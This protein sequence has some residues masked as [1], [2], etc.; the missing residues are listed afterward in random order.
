M[1]SKSSEVRLGHLI[2]SGYHGRIEYIGQMGTRIYFSHDLDTL[3]GCLG[4]HLREPVA[5]ADPFQP[6]TVI[7]PNAHMKR[8][9][10]ISLAERL[11]IVANVEFPILPFGL[12]QLLDDLSSSDPETE[13][14]PLR[15]DL[16]RLQIMGL[17]LARTRPGEADDDFAQ[18]AF[19]L[20]DKNGKPARNFAGRLWQISAQLAHYF[21]EYEFHRADMIAAWRRNESFKRIP[22]EDPEVEGMETCQRSLYNA[23]FADNGLRDQLAA[24]LQEEYLTLPQFSSR[25][26]PKARPITQPVH[27]FALSQISSY[28]RNLLFRLGRLVDLHVYQLNLCSE[29]WEDVTTEREDRWLR[30]RNAK[31][32]NEHGE[33]VLEWDEYENMLLKWWGKPGRESARL[34]SE[35]ENES[36]PELNLEI[37]WLETDSRAPGSTVLATVQQQV[38]RRQQL[39]EGDR[40][41]QDRSL[42]IVAAPGLFREIE[43]IHQSVIDNLAADPTLK[44]TD[45]AILVPDINQY[46]PVIDAVFN[47]RPRPIEYNLTDSTAAKDSIYGQAVVDLLELANGSFSRREVFNLILNPCFLAGRGI[48]RDDALIWAQWAEHLQI[49]HSFD[50]ADKEARG[51]TPNRLFTW[52]QGLERLRFGRIMLQ[53]PEQHFHE[54]VP[55]A[56]MQSGDRQ[57]LSNF[58]FTIEALFRAIQRIAAVELSCEA[59]L[60]ELETVLDAFLGIPND[61]PEEAM[62]RRQLLESMRGHVLID[63]ILD[64]LDY[65]DGIGFELVVQMVNACLDDIASRH[66]SFL[67][68]G[69]NVAEIRANRAIPHRIVYIAGMREGQFPGSP[70]V[71]TLDLRRPGR[72]IGDISLPEENRF[73]ILETL[74]T[75]RDK[76]YLS[77]VSRDL[78]KDQVFYP[79]SIIV[80]LKTY[81]ERAV[82]DGEFRI[83]EVP[84]SSADE[85]YLRWDTQ[86]DWSDVIVNR[87]ES[88]RILALQ[89]LMVRNPDRISPEV[90]DE[91]AAR[92]ERN[93][94]QARAL[95]TETRDERVVLRLRDLRRF[96]ENPIEA[97]F[98]TQLSI[99]EA[100]EDISDWA[101]AEDEPFFS[102]R[103]VSRVLVDHVL[104]E[105]IR[106]R[107]KGVDRAVGD[108]YD[109]RLARMYEDF[110]RRSRTPEGVFSRLDRELILVE[111]ENRLKG[112]RPADSLNR[113]L[114]ELDGMEFIDTACIGTPEDPEPVTRA[115]PPLSLKLDSGEVELH[116]ELPL[117]WRDPVTGGI[118][119]MH[120]THDKSY[121]RRFPTP[122]QLLTPFLFYVMNRA[123]D[124]DLFGDEPFAVYWSNRS[125]V[126]CYRFRMKQESAGKYLLELLTE[127]TGPTAFE[128]LPYDVLTRLTGR[129]TD[130]PIPLK[131]GSF[132]DD[133]QKMQYHRRLQRE[134]EEQLDNPWSQWWHMPILD[135][136]ELQVPRDAWDKIN[137]R[138]GPFHDLL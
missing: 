7:V 136:M 103:D 108:M 104:G 109:E 32:S 10:Q 94:D 79:C 132:A 15:F 133:R 37:E 116:A 86:D 61:R 55:Y 90:R 93:I 39:A 21:V 131:S 121:H 72:R 114:R 64:Q 81:L 42:Q 56:D 102:D 66:G 16:L 18:L 65:D 71:S 41:T 89:A 68:G 36:A 123:S 57:L 137:R 28:H 124:N 13:R 83:A 67:S 119:A 128:V 54:I 126:D 92:L 107:A 117:L 38:L 97:A 40:L 46:K 31:T 22:T 75:V 51:L 106:T 82:L 127:F 1:T 122:R 9:L 30:L 45:F 26:L 20:Y 105:H 17:I 99:Y 25:V 5:D 95:V 100:S 88:D 23:L 69:V 74:M 6:A 4:E 60:A 53:E 138:F 29:F 98:R 96:L 14:M 35:L 33:E 52:Q 110:Q 134:V 48:E 80:Q 120:L 50:E 47:R 59:W 24:V 125:K 77:Y 113:A 2:S 19:M 27:I 63:P 129:N 78:Q 118:S 112:N 115:L 135:V 101:L 130:L 12:W 49:F 111:I 87:S 8:W 73:S 3:S 44:Q 34:F 70:D 62:V 11:G 85:Q 84:V 43:T 91:L 76:L 58:C